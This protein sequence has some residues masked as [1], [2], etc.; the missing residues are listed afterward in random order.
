MRGGHLGS[1]RAGGFLGRYRYYDLAW[2]DR[3]SWRYRYMACATDAGATAAAGCSGDVPQPSTSLALALAL[4][5][6]FT[7]NICEFVCDPSSPY[8]SNS[9]SARTDNGTCRS[10]TAHQPAFWRGRRHKDDSGRC[11]DDKHT[12]H[13]PPSVPQRKSTDRTS[14]HEWRMTRATEQG[15][16]AHLRDA[17]PMAVGWTR[18]RHAGV[19]NWTVTPHMPA[20]PLAVPPGG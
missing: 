1:C 20:D 8:S 19:D 12:H 10:I 15:T 5:P 7:L 9:T 13:H 4:S 2:A 18:A 3:R 11:R 14:P 6:L 16:T 17:R